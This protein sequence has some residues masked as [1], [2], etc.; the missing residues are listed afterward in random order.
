M[1]QV[2]GNVT[3][4]PI[5]W[6]IELSKMSFFGGEIFGFSKD[7]FA[8]HFAPLCTEH[9]LGIWLQLPWLQHEACRL[10]HGIF[11]KM[12]VALEKMDS[13]WKYMAIFWDIYVRPFFF[14]N[15]AEYVCLFPFFANA[16]DFWHK[17]P[18]KVVQMTS[19]PARRATSLGVSFSNAKDVSWEHG[20]GDDWD[21]VV[22]YFFLFPGQLKSCL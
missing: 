22:S 20:I 19:W 7:A 3:T 10:H 18:A 1:D 8:L 5:N 4:F 15:T 2:W 13:G 16:W 11:P 17:P 6:Q 12:M 21:D 14:L 9:L